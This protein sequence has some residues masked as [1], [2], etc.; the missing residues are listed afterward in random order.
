MS[1]YKAGILYYNIISKFTEQTNAWRLFDM[2]K[3]TIVYKNKKGKIIK[4]E[5]LRFGC[6]RYVLFD[7]AGTFVKDL[8]VPFRVADYL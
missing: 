3:E 1:V 8:S 7:A 2:V 5:D 4:I 6:A